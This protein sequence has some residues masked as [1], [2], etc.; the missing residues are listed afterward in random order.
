MKAQVTTESYIKNDQ[1][2]TKIAYLYNYILNELERQVNHS[3]QL[4]V[5]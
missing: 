1:L 4:M 5:S 2:C 3:K